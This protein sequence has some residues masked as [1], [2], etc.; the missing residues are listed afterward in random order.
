MNEK[1]RQFQFY[2]GWIMKMGRTNGILEY[3]LT[4]TTKSNTGELNGG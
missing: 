1:Q 2:S 3:M 4:K